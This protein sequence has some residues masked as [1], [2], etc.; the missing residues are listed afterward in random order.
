MAIK[1][2]EASDSSSFI[3]T[4]V[5]KYHQSLAKTWLRLWQAFEEHLFFTYV[6]LKTAFLERSFRALDVCAPS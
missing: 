3:K 2:Q 1:Q 6:A 5:P 4:I